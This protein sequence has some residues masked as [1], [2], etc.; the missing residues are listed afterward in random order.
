[1]RWKHL[2][3]LSISGHRATDPKPAKNKY[4]STKG[5]QNK[6]QFE[7]LNHTVN[8]LQLCLRR[9]SPVAQQ[10]TRAED[11]LYV[12]NLVKLR[13]FPSVKFLWALLY[14]AGTLGVPERATVMLFQ[15]NGRSNNFPLRP[16]ANLS[17]TTQRAKTIKLSIGRPTPGGPFS[18]IAGVIKRKS[19]MKI[20]RPEF[21]H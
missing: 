1:M 13:N 14:V 8:K 21:L 5:K 7:T 11:V 19:Q 4:R 18:R 20:K 16:S 3:F 17:C 10:F 12:E 9:R 15:R 6:I 2:P